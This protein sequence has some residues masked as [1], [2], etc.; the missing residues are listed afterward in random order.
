MSFLR[1]FHPDFGNGSDGV[2]TLTGVVGKQVY[3]LGGGSSIS[4]LTL[5]RS[6]IP[7]IIRCNGPLTISGDIYGDGMGSAGGNGTQ[8]AGSC[9]YGPGRG[10]G[11]PSGS[12]FG[13]SGA[14][15]GHNGSGANGSNGVPN[16]PGG[17]PYDGVLSALLGSYGPWNAGSGGGQAGT[18]NSGAGPTGGFGGGGII[19][20]APSI[21]WSA[22]VAY[23]RGS[24]GG[25]GG[26]AGSGGGSG[27][28]IV[29]IGYVIAL[30]GAGTYIYVNGGGGGSGSSYSGGAGA[31]GR[32][33][34]IYLSGLTGS[35]GIVTPSAAQVF[36]IASR[37][38]IG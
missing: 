23:L 8:W 22:G 6:F 18:A 32:A 24:A 17:D 33:G 7:S 4:G 35:T 11:G 10:G 16:S 3:N 21:T 14:G 25:N 1:P 36:N 20:I 27:G 13:Q 38:Q 37:P 31:P 9:G 29:L 30:P 28:E 5:S 19:I 34:F 12:T 2:I 15:A 26:S